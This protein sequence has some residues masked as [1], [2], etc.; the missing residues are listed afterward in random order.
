MS[1]TSHQ[2]L[3]AL[4]SRPT[5]LHSLDLK[6]HNLIN[7]AW[8]LLVFKLTIGIVSAYDIYLTVKYVDSLPTLELNPVGRWLMSLDTGPECELQQ[9]ALFITAKFAG[10]FIALAII[11][12]LCSWKLSIASAVAFCVALMQ[13]MLLYFLVFG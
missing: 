2:L 13:L 12:L 1:T 9:V 6:L 4:D 7:S 11:E 10:N 5:L 8:T 3:V